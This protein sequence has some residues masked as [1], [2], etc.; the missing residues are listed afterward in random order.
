MTGKNHEIKGWQGGH[1]GP[2]QRGPNVR[3]YGIMAPDTQVRP[4]VARTMAG[5]AGEAVVGGRVVRFRDRFRGI[6][7]KHQGSENPF[8]VGREALGFQL[9]EGMLL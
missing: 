9:G 7:E 2:P 5:Q 4:N 3:P 6:E 1:T 8:S